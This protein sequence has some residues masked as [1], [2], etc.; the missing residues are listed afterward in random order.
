M[1][2]Q[3]H[4]SS[5]QDRPKLSSLSHQQQQRQ[6]QPKQQQQQASPVLK[7]AFNRQ[8][9]LSQAQ[10]A[11][12]TS[13]AQLDMPG[14]PT[15]MQQAFWVGRSQAAS[16]DASNATAR[17]VNSLAEGPSPVAAGVNSV[18][19]GISPS[20][21]EISKEEAT[22]ELDAADAVASQLEGLQ[23]TPL[24]Q[25]LMLCGQQVWHC[26]AAVHQPLGHSLQQV[27]CIVTALH[28]CSN[29]LAIQHIPALASLRFYLFWPLMCCIPFATNIVKSAYMCRSRIFSAFPSAP[30]MF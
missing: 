8:D 24:Q 20:P 21:A 19:R 14:T 29:H 9:R 13:G 6:Q 16:S 10:A 4:A 26:T 28:G 12:S 7:G 5:L 27:C 30:A 15:A 1:L 2:P 17:R 22:R 18:A 25:L 11:N 3:T 23:L